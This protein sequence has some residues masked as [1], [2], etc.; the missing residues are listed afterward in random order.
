MASKEK[1]VLYSAIWGDYYPFDTFEIFNDFQVAAG[2]EDLVNKG[3]LV[4]WGGEDISPSLYNA[5]VSRYTGATE[6]PSRRDRVEWALMN[7]AVELEMPIIGI[8]RGAQMLCA[9]AGGKLIQ[10]VNGHGGHHFVDTHDGQSLMVNSLHH[11]MMY[12][13]EV[14]HEMVA[15]SSI[16]RSEVHIDEDKDIEVP[17]EPEFVYFPK[18]K[19]FAIQWHPEM[20]RANTDATEYIQSFMKGK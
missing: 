6:E 18:V 16:I 17:K 20:M 1:F 15:W 19:G 7:R 4:V 14:D 9:L 2:P 10:H 13:F 3:M 8:C 12:P 11:Q 5:K